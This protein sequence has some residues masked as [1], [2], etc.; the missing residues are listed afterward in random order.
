MTRIIVN[1]HFNMKPREKEYYKTGET[2]A[3]KITIYP[4]LVHSHAGQI[5]PFPPPLPQSTNSRS[6]NILVQDWLSQP[7][8][9]PMAIS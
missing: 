3:Y 4:P 9:H 1:S 8:P 6:F 2:T 5:A 7:H